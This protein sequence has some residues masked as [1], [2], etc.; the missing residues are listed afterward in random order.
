LALQSKISRNWWKWI[1]KRTLR[2]PHKGAKR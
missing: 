1:P 2:K